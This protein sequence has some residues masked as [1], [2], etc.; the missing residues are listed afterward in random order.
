VELDLNREY[1]M[2]FFI[3]LNHSRI[4]LVCAMQRG[5]AVDSLSSGEDSELFRFWALIV[6]IAQLESVSF[7]SKSYQKDCA[8]RQPGIH[9]LCQSSV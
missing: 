8:V 2:V 5:N 6:E 9:I 7:L 4:D 1:Q 3:K